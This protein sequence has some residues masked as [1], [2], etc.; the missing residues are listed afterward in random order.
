MQCWVNNIFFNLFSEQDNVSYLQITPP[1][2]TLIY[3]FHSLWIG[4]NI[5]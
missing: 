3:T 1:V 5:W 4:Y 2:S